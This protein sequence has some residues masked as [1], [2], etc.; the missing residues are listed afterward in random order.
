MTTIGGRGALVYN[1]KNL[2]RKDPYYYEGEV[3]DTTGAGDSWITGFMTAYLE[4][5]KRLDW[6]KENET[7][8]FIREVD[9][10]DY[11]ENLI[12]YGMSMGNLLARKNCLIK[13][14]FGYGTRFQNP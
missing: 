11:M 2:F 1:G 3:E 13:G 7:D 10:E 14:S 12:K 9:E 4:G 8:R 5:K 6:L